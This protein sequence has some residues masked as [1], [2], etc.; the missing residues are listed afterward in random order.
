M[1][2]R[3]RPTPVGT[4]RRPGPERPAALARP[5]WRP[6]GGRAARGQ[7]VRPAAP[8]V[9]RTPRSRPRRDA[10]P[11]G[12]D[13][14]KRRRQSREECRGLRPCSARVRLSRTPCTH[15]PHELQAPP[16]AEGRADARR[17]DRRRANG[18]RS[19]ASLAPPTVRARRPPSWACRRA[20]R[21]FRT[22]GRG[23]APVDA[24]LVGGSETSAEV[25]EE[26]RKR[27]AAASGRECFAPGDLRTL[28]RGRARS[29][30]PCRSWRRLYARPAAT[31]HVARK[32]TPR[33]LVSFCSSGYSRSSTPAESS[34]RDP[35]ADRRLRPLRLLPAD[36]P[37]VR[38][39]E[40][41]DGLA[42]RAHPPHGCPAR[43]DGHAQLDRLHSLR[44][45]P[46]LHGVPELVPFRRSLRPA[47]RE[48]PSGRRGGVRA[49]A[50]RSLRPRASVPRPALSRSH[51]SSAPPCAA[52][53]DRADAAT[54]PTLVEIAPRWRGKGEVPASP[55]RWGSGMHALACSPDACRAPSSLT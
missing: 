20:L 48:H 39:L 23:P 13:R 35:G 19:A 11:C 31:C 40:R 51:E 52:R 32:A 50:R 27:Q 4:Q 18:R 3:G 14:R 21:R 49:S 34:R 17:R 15:R 29:C 46:R 44:P 9:R 30:R 16:A 28:P 38:P 2:G 41:G 7:P 45:L 6:D 54:V 33:T 10:R 1:Y 43:R 25:W 5:A 22:S 47:H 26:S 55:L 53:P 37:D 12:R 24:A 42:A 8:S 36:V